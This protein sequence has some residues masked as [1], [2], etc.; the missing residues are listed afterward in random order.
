MA[1]HDMLT[2]L[3]NRALF[4]D[5]TEHA[6]EGADRTGEA[7]AVLFVDLDGFKLINDD[8]GHAVGDSVLIEVAARL[9][10]CARQS[11]TIGRLGGDE[12]AI[13]VERMADPHD[14]ERFA[15][16]IIQALAEP[17][18]IGDASVTVT[19]SASVGVALRRR[20]H[21]RADDLLLD[22]DHAMYVAKSAGKGQYV[23]AGQTSSSI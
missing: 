9:R 18:E 11:D 14:A 8:H 6:I 4:Y 1:F 23:L 10:T 13:L 12:F 7:L 16:R 3:A 19:V 2:G 20:Q 17:M 15:D 22:A 5:R 21:V